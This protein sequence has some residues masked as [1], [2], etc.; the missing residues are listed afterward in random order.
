MVS[1]IAIREYP[2]PDNPLTALYRTGWWTYFWCILEYQLGLICTC[3]PS[4]Q[5]CIKRTVAYCTRQRETKLASQADSDAELTSLYTQSRRKP[6]SI[7]SKATADR[8]SHEDIRVSKTIEVSAATMPRPSKSYVGVGRGSS[9]ASVKSTKSTKSSH[10]PRIRTPKTPRESVDFFSQF[11]E[12]T[13]WSS[14]SGWLDDSSGNVDKDLPPVPPVP[15]L[16]LSLPRQEVEKGF[17]GPAPPSL[18]P[19]KFLRH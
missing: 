1:V 6:M 7:W 10:T 3:A 18:P 2:F 11:N 5:V 16:P 14:F 17:T 15:P 12:K 9:T 4:I 8:T 13:R 19:L